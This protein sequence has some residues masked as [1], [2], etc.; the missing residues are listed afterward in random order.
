MKFDLFFGL[1]LGVGNLLQLIILANPK[2][3]NTRKLS[4][5]DG[6]HIIELEIHTY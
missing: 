6:Q 5:A 1:V 2:Y 4:A 3:V